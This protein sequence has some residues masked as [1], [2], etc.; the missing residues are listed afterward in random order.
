[1]ASFIQRVDHSVF[2]DLVIAP[3]ST[4][5]IKEAS[6]MLKDFWTSNNV[7][8]NG[9]LT[10]ELYRN[11]KIK[12][13]KLGRSKSDGAAFMNGKAIV[14]RYSRSIS[15]YS[16][17]VRRDSKDSVLSS[18]KEEEIA[19]DRQS[20]AN[21]S[22]L[23]PYNINREERLKRGRSYS[24]DSAIPQAKTSVQRQRQSSCGSRSLSRESSIEEESEVNKEAVKQQ[25]QRRVSR[26]VDELLLEIYGPE[27]A[28][29]LSSAQESDCCSTSGT[30]TSWRTQSIQ[31]AVSEP[32]QQARLKTKDVSELRTLHTTLRAHVQFV[33]SLL[34]RQLKR[35][36]ALRAR[37][38][39]NNDV[40]TALLQALSPKR[41]I[42]TMKA[43][44][45]GVQRKSTKAGERRKYW[46]SGDNLCGSC[47]SKTIPGTV[48]ARDKKAL[49]KK[50]EAG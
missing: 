28:R 4:P 2:G 9:G 43:E 38:D 30:T 26:L 39:K 5:D 50:L 33:G 35:R 8:E 40:I 31:R 44:S 36:D 16:G 14:P 12:N 18:M 22:E 29:R 10:F 6:F 23:H 49:W 11:A 1:M 45:V 34:V 27:C 46:R 32:L 19:D 3:Q 41:N 7:Y 15:E 24:Y 47:A 48:E 21:D 17:M 20:C 13:R 25:R 42:V 37:R